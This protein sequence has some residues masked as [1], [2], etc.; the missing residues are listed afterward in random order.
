MEM[1]AAVLP[2]ILVVIAAL[3]AFG[4]LLVIPITAAQILKVAFEEDNL[5][6]LRGEVPRSE[7]QIPA[8][9]PTS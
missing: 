4:C 2:K 9:T 5:Q 1:V 7:P 3:G 6:E 8:S